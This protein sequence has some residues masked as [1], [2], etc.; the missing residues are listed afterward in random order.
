MELTNTQS[1][2]ISDDK[3]IRP[4]KGEVDRLRANINKA[5][6]YISWEP[7]LKGKRGLRLGLEKTIKWFS[8]NLKNYK[9]NIYNT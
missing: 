3:R 7:K 2:I 9:T 5:K 8:K 4:K 1:K 6:K